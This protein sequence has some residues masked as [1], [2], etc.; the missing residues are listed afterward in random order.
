MR[1]WFLVL[2]LV[3]IALFL[4]FGCAKAQEADP[5]GAQES[6]SLIVYFSLTGNTELVATQIQSLTG[7][8]VFKLELVDPY[9]VEYDEV[10]S[11]SRQEREEGILPELAQKI[12]DLDDFDVIFLGSPNWFGTLSLPIFAFIETHDL[13]GKTIVPFI[14]HGRGGLM[15]TIT[16]LVELCPDAAVLE[17]FGVSRDDVETIQSDIEEWLNRVGILE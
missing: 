17:G 4:L 16:D 13:S 7:S 2:G 12:E 11:R 9:S 1:K 6:R 5:A 15:N 8:D 3:S 14:T 10:I